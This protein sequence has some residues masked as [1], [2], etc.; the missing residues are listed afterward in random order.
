MQGPAPEAMAGFFRA[1]F[2]AI[3]GWMET[4]AKAGSQARK[5]WIYA[6]TRLRGFQ[7]PV[8]CHSG[9]A[10]IFRKIL[11]SRLPLPPNDF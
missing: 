11:P 2:S 8:S 7:R 9:H 4:Q 5:S 1:V 6:I 10:S 3:W